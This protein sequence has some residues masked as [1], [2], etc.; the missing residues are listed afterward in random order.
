[1]S[2]HPVFFNN[3]LPEAS[4][5]SRHSRRK[6][7]MKNTVGLNPARGKD[8]EIYRPT[9]SVRNFLEPVTLA[10]A[11][12][13]KQGSLKSKLRETQPEIGLSEPR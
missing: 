13:V 11:A 10:R 8:D 2:M 6:S 7:F 3:E 4:V 9:I 1:M 12:S 5:Q